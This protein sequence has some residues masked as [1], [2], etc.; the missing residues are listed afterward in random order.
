MLLIHAFLPWMCYPK[1]GRSTPWACQCHSK[2]NN[3]WPATSRSR[4]FLAHP[5]E[6]PRYSPVQNRLSASAPLQHLICWTTEDIQIKAGSFL[7]CGQFHQELVGHVA[8][9]C[10]SANPCQT[11]TYL[12]NMQRNKQT[13]GTCH[14]SRPTIWQLKNESAYAEL[15]V[16]NKALAVFLQK[17]QS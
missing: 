14:A 4:S 11:N 8:R 1:R 15:L 3:T 9:S 10:Q 17:N 5:L 13:F 6:I 12:Y 2:S 16:P 7:K